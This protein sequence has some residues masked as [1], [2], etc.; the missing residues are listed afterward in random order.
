MKILQIL[1]SK[2]KFWELETLILITASYKKQRVLGDK[3][4]KEIHANL[5]TQAVIF[6]KEIECLIQFIDFL[7]KMLVELINGELDI[8]EYD[9]DGRTI[10]D[11]IIYFFLEDTFSPIKHNE[12]LVEYIET[13]YK[14]DSIQNAGIKQTFPMLN[15]SNED[16]SSQITQHD[17]FSQST[18]DDLLRIETLNQLEY[19]RTTMEVAY[20][21]FKAQNSPLEILDFLKEEGIIEA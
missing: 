7:K 21:M 18:E 15:I 17:I 14:M 9:E 10:Y 8:D 12:G 5:Y 1:R 6:R 2:L 20:E 3:N 4:E 11:N 13:R 16:E 19:F